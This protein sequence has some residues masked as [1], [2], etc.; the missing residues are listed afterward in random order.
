M[1]NLGVT[2]HSSTNLNLM[3]FGGS[4]PSRDH[5]LKTGTLELCVVGWSPKNTDTRCSLVTEHN[6]VGL[7][8]EGAQVSPHVVHHRGVQQHL[9]WAAAQGMVGFR[10]TLL[11]PHTVERETLLISICR[12]LGKAHSS[13]G[14][15]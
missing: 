4:C 8:G 10:F 9:E 14:W 5:Q 1:I 3:T 7:P 6:R 2:V 13:E 15:C 12:F 11:L